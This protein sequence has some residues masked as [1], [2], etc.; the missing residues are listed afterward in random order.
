MVYCSIEE[1]WGT[2][3]TNNKTQSKTNYDHIVADNASEH[4][5]NSTY[6][7]VEFTRDNAYTKSGAP[8]LQRNRTSSYTKKKRRKSYSRNMKR[9][10]NHSGPDDRYPESRNSKHLEFTD[11]VEMEA[12]PSKR[13][14]DS[15]NS[16]SPSYKNTDTG[17]SG[18][19][20]T[21]AD[22]L[23]QHEDLKRA[24][25]YHKKHRK[26][27]PPPREEIDS[28][29][30]FDSES[31]YT[32]QTDTEIEE[33]GYSDSEY[34]YPYQEESVHKPLRKET[35]MDLSDSVHKDNLGNRRSKRLRENMFDIIIYVITGIFIIFILDVFVRLGKSA[36]SQ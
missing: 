24:K 9:L 7:E 28:E 14:R 5:D 1:A 3:F 4:G 16:K 12:Y 6:G 20:N 36:S 21:L 19:N 33:E 35:Y 17:I 26:P 29:T 11:N 30:E 22:S 13:L 10:P 23:V 32:K 31:E 2:N 8:V 27:S 25:R 15:N 18:Y 34:E